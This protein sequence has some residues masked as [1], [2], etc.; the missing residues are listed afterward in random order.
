MPV[1]VDARQCRFELAIDLQLAEKL[2]AFR[3]EIAFA[4]CFDLAVG[5][6]TISDTVISRLKQNQT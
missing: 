1:P 3:P 6:K 2:Y 5:L 4:N